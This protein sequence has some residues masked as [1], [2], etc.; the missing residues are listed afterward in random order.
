M[1]QVIRIPYKPRKW[2]QEFH[3]TKKR[4]ILLILHRRAGK[5][6]ALVNHLQRT[7]CQIEKS[8]T[9][10]IGPTYRQAER[11]AWDIAKEVSRPIPGVRQTDL[12]V[13]YP[14][15]AKLYL[16]GQEN[17][18]SLRGM[19]LWGAAHDEYPMH[20]PTVF[21]TVVS[22]ALAD[23]LGYSIFAGTPKGK[24]DFWRLF[25]IAKNSEDWLVIHRTIDDS[26]R[27]E[28][29]E[30]ID[31]LRV[32]VE[33]DRRLIQQGLMTQDEFDQEW[34]C[35]F[36]ASI[37]GAYYAKEIAQARKEGRVR[38]VPHDPALKVHTVW[39]LGIGKKLVVGFYQKFGPE[40]RMIDFEYGDDGDGLPQM[41]NRVERKN[42]IYGQH[43]APHDVNAKEIAT[44]KTRYDTAKNLGIEFSVVPEI[45]V[46][47]G[48]EK[49]KLFFSRLW[50]NDPGIPAA[51]GEPVKGVP[52]WLDAISQYREEYDEDENFLKGKEHVDWTNDPADVHRYA[53]L[54]EDQMTN[55][56][57]SQ[58][59]SFIPEW[60]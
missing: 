35:S 51:I 21:S 9:A 39:D 13:T 52:Y 55:D 44:G 36:N 60:D 45:P 46:E 30:T 16:L 23:H 22:K 54:V 40:V 56:V 33:D 11:I 5:T 8:K 25:E 59:S 37:K 43:F 50:I 3:E 48:I 7:N 2:T 31:N 19:A 10:Y 53:A 28:Q 14:N 15:Y 58:M 27:D 41:I 49:G 32:A 26:L 1:G 20:N 57:T 4:W 24:N 42:Y 17:P 18:D 6:T 34:Y 38:S 29:G 47:M 12:T